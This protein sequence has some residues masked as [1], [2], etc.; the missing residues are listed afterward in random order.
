MAK[1]RRPTKSIEDLR[2]EIAHTRDRLARDLTGLRYEMDFPL[3]FRKSFQRHSK[4]WISAATLLGTIFTVRPS[5]RRK[6]VKVK[7]GKFDFAKKGEEEK[8]GMLMAGLSMGALRFA[9]T[10]L[11][12]VVVRFVT[13][14][15]GSYNRAK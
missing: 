11:K 6:T 4:I 8:K 2:Q 5:A 1:E 15:L 13:N 7:S 10:L 3:K 12:P 14:K 9:A